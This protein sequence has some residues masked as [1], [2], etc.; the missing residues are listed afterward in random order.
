MDFRILGPL[1]VHGDLGAIEVPGRKRRAVLAV[2]LLHANE[3]VSPE[4]LAVALWGEDA[5]AS[6]VKNVHV[7][8]SRLRKAL[9]DDLV[10][11]TP[12]GYRLRVAS[13]E[14]DVDRFERLVADGR[15]TLAGGQADEAGIVLREAL[16]LW[17]GP[18]LADLEFEPFARV[19]VE[20][21]GELRLAAVED[22]IDAELV[23]G[24]QGALVPELEAL[25]A[26]HPLRERL[27]A[28]LMRALYANACQAEALTVYADTRKLLVEE[29]GIE[30]GEELRELERKV[31]NHDPG[32]RAALPP[33]RRAARDDT[34]PSRDATGPIRRRRSR[35]AVV[36]ALLGAV[37]DAA[38]TGL[39]LR[40]E[41]P[42]AGVLPGSIAFI[43]ADSGK[44][45]GHFIGAPG[46]IVLWGAGSV[47]TKEDSGNII[48]IDPRS[49]RQ[50]RSIPVGLTGGGSA[51]GQGALWVSGSSQTLARV[52]P[53]YGGVTRFRLPRRGLVRP[54][55]GGGVAVGAGSVWVA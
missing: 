33:P 1:E 47:W 2:L 22:R 55:L 3:P 16:N 28:Q 21:L 27:R 8:I 19:E 13:G 18:P 14:L 4:R 44:P 24:R 54:T 48:Q 37:A 39:L 5:P 17:R 52:E 36:A 23:L 20:R 42:A 31:L 40:G 41:R 38:A 30:P 7:L 32:L 43:A 26:E 12:A 25:I 6:A 53:R 49:F 46:P 9:G 35:G 34:G 15:R 51:V 45:V 10:Q 11:T 50:I 29:L